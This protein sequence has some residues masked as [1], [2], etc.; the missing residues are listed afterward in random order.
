MPDLHEVV[1]TSASADH[2]VLRRAAIDRAVGANL[3]IIPDKHTAKLGDGD[4]TRPLRGFFGGEAKALLADAHAG[5]QKHAT[6]QHGMA[7]GDM[8]GNPAILADLHGSGD[9]RAGAY[10]HTRAN[11]HASFD[12]HERADLGSGV[13]LGGGIDDG[14]WVDADDGGRQRVEQRGNAGPAEIGLAGHDRRG[15]R[16]HQM[17]HIRMDNHRAGT[18]VTERGCVFSIVEK[19]HRAGAGGLQGGHMRER[20]LCR[21]SSPTG[22]RRNGGQIMRAGAAEEPGVSHKSLARHHLPACATR[23]AGNPSTI[24]ADLRPVLVPG[25]LTQARPAQVRLE[26]QRRRRPEGW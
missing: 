1:D 6:P 10:P 22:R 24:C 12:H 26:S 19:T 9:K 7:D 16:R 8:R 5:K 15:L 14:A 21:D 3:H 18:C 13:D 4:E 20:Q 23:I 25:G 17:R 11:F 2:G